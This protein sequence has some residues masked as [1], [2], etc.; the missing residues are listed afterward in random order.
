MLCVSTDILFEYREIMDQK[1]GFEVAENV[2]N[3]I[4]VMP[5]TEHIHVFYNFN[6]IREDPDDNKFV[7]CAI[8]ASAH[9]LVSNDGHYE[10]LLSVAFPKINWIRLTDFDKQYKDQLAVKPS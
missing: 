5:E 9:Y 7:D 10:A 2:L 4:T 6:L 3:F 1:S 8:A